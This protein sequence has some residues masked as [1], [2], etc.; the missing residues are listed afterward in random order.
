VLLVILQEPLLPEFPKH[1]RRGPFLKAAVGGAAVTD[2]GGIQRVPLAAGAQHEKDRIQGPARVDRRAMAPQGMRLAR[3][4]Q[5]V[6]ALPE[7]VGNPPAIVLHVI[8]F[9]GRSSGWL[10]PEQRL[11]STY[12]DRV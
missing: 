5:R 1:A 4:E 9:H 6:D 3:R 2:P 8:L 7:C 11:S 12:R 10:Y